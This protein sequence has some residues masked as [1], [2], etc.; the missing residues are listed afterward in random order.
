MTIILSR[1][2]KHFYNR[3][4]KAVVVQV[5]QLC[6]INE[7]ER[8][9]KEQVKS[10]HAHPKGFW[11]LCDRHFSDVGMEPWCHQG[12]SMRKLMYSCPMCE[13]Q[14]SHNSVPPSKDCPNCNSNI[15]PDS[16][17]FEIKTT[18]HKEPVSLGG[19]T[20]VRCAECDAES[21]GGKEELGHRKA[22]CRAK[23]ALKYHSDHI[24]EMKEEVKQEVAQILNTEKQYD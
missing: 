2:G 18:Q 24:D 8:E 1:W 15:E 5:K 10:I 17:D 20:Y 11:H 19:T 6:Q 3:F 21:I 12:N 7:C 13:S 22:T 4:G 14:F 16:I 23:H 9:A